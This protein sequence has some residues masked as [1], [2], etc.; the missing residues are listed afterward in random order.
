MEP[1]YLH[2]TV[3]LIDHETNLDPGSLLLPKNIELPAN[4]SIELF[5]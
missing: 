4:I 1:T 2:P 3:L 5:T